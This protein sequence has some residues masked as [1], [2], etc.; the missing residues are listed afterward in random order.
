AYPGTNPLD[1]F[2]LVA[3]HVLCPYR[4]C[5][6]ATTVVEWPWTIGI[7]KLS[8]PAWA[9]PLAARLLA[10]GHMSASRERSGASPPV[11]AGSESGAGPARHA[12]RSQTLIGVH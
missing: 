11:D 8:Q 2:W 6:H 3:Q 10:E 12:S 4:P 7:E 5:R 1:K 9:Q